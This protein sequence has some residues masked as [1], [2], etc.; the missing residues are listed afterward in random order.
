METLLMAIVAAPGAVFLLLS[1]SWLAGWIPSERIVA[2]DTAA[3]VTFIRALPT[4]PIRL[5]FKL[6]N[7]RLYAFQFA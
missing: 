4:E 7:A 1:L 5:R 6:D 3:E 2:N